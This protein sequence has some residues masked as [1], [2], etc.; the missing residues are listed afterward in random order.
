MGELRILNKFSE[1]MVNFSRIFIIYWP[2]KTEIGDNNDNTEYIQTIQ[3]K[4]ENTHY[5]F[6]HDNFGNGKVFMAVKKTIHN[7]TSYNV[8]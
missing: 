6:H 1:Y 8:Y 3:Q 2:G 7:A 4:I 5:C